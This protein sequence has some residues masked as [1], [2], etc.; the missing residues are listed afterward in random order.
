[1][2]GGMGMA[3]GGAASAL[4]GFAD[5]YEQT[6]DWKQAASGG[7]GAGIGA[8]AGMGL[9]ALGIP[10]PLSTMIGGA[11]GGLATKGINKIFK[12]TGG[13]GKGRKRSLKLIEN[14]IKSGGRFDFGAPSGLSNAMGLGVGGYEKTP[15]EAN[16][17]KMVEKLGTSRLVA[18]MGVPAP[19]LIA[20]AQGQ[21]GG[22]QASKMYS[23][24]NRSLY[25]NTP[26]RYRKALSIP[27]LADGGIVNR[28]TTALIG[29][30]GP[31]A[32]V[33]LGDSPMIQEL[34]KQNKLMAEMIKTQ[35]ETAQ[36][37]I[38]MDGRVVS[39]VVGQNFYEIGNGL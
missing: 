4:V 23:T 25:G 8:A 17:N 37:E 34:K 2:E 30:R 29:E 24:I 31:E 19:A 14:H 18:S 27:S 21:M 26:D 6:G 32:V 5:I 1:M 33:P 36:T 13:Y 11:I 10:P 20:L 22:N 35:K 38:R 39:E 28:P 12:I 7:V 15:T 9:T 16:F 3:K